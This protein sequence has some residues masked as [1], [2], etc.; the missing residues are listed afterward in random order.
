[1]IS[2]S[3]YH[4]VDT[5]WVA[6]LGYQAIAALTITFPYFILVIAIGAGTGVGAN[7]LASRRFGER[8]VEAT[9]QVA[10]QVFLLSAIFGVIFLVAAVFFAEGVESSRDHD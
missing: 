4:L 6:K 5:F 2:I 7:A 10:G 3:L 9:N 8:N 1:M